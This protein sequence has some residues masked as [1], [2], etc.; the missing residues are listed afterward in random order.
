MESMAGIVDAIVD[1]P[2]L[3]CSAKQ[4]SSRV[5]SLHCVPNK[6]RPG[7]KL[8][9]GCWGYGKSAWL[10]LNSRRKERHVPSVLR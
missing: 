1:V 9:A 10:A 6:T 4:F 5:L 2:S 7:A 8:C 3:E